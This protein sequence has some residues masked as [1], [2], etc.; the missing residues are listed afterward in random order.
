MVEKITIVSI[1]V[2]KNDAKSA[3][4]GRRKRRQ[5]A[6]IVMIPRVCDTHILVSGGIHR[7]GEVFNIHMVTAIPSTALV[8]TRTSLFQATSADRKLFKEA[9]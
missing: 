7:M 1:S 3:R 2:I 9:Y 5:R 6:E 8:V 4:L